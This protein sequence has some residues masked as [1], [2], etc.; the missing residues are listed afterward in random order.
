LAVPELPQLGVAEAT[1]RVLPDRREVVG[2]LVGIWT[3]SRVAPAQ[4]LFG[5]QA[6]TSPLIGGRIVRSARAGPGALVGSSPV[7]SATGASARTGRRNPA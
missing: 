4:P 5:A 2:L 7:A 3:H 1:A 6:K